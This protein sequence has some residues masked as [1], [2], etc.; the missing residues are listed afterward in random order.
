MLTAVPSS[1]QRDALLSGAEQFGHSKLGKSAS[2]VFALA[3]MAG[4]YIG[5]AFTFYITVVTG[6]SGMPWGLSRLLGGLVFSLGLIL[7]VV[8]GAELFTSTVLTIIPWANGQISGRRL[9]SHWGRVFAGNLTGALLLVALLVTADQA[10][11]FGGQWGLQVMSVAQHK[12]EHSFWQA[13]ALGV[14]CNLLVCLG[15]WMSFSTKDPV[16]KSLLLI[17]PVAMF[18]STG[19]EHSIANLFLVPLGIAIH[20]LADAAFWANLGV[21]ADQFADLT[22]SHFLI[23]N[24]MPVTLG[25]IIGGGVFVGL[26]HWWIHGRHTPASD[27]D[28]HSNSESKGNHTMTYTTTPLTAA[29]LCDHQPLTLTPTTNVAEAS[30]ALLRQGRAAALVLDGD[31]PVAIVDDQDLLR[32]F[33]LSEFEDTQLMEIAKVMQPL[34]F[35]CSADEPLTKLACR[36]AVDEDKLYPVSSSGYLTSFNVENIEQRAMNAVPRAN[37]LVVVMDGKRVVGVID[38]R[39]VLAALAGELQA[40]QAPDMR[41]EANVA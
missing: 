21:N 26:A 33:Y 24:L 19:F 28:T 2:R 14:L 39:K 32:A 13:V 3:V 22:V 17:L 9:L 31:R 38:R 34:T 20:S 35:S 41:G 7:V 16:G 12:L 15:I 5:I 11:Q 4:L 6:S 37:A 10:S 36:L 8:C 1:P 25:N 27:T 23:N 29:D 18:V 30:Q 40:M